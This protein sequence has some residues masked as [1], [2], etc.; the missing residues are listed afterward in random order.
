MNVGKCSYSLILTKDCFVI[1]CVDLQGILE[2]SS[3]TNLD[4]KSTSGKREAYGPL[5]DTE[6]QVKR[7]RQ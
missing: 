2:E 1:V 6:H 4:Q 3:K 7:T 5:G